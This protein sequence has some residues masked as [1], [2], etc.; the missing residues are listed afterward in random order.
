MCVIPCMG[1]CTCFIVFA[2]MAE[3]SGLT[4]GRGKRAR[5]LTS[6]VSVANPGKRRTKVRVTG[7]I[8]TQIITD[9]QDKVNSDAHATSPKG[10]PMLPLQTEQAASEE[11]FDFSEQVSVNLPSWWTKGSPRLLATDTPDHVESV[12]ATNFG[13]GVDLDRYLEPARSI[14]ERFSTIEREEYK[15]K[16]SSL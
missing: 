4:Q 9:A 10:P 11:N 2:V 13:A 3:E 6:K 15:K 1:K 12:V 8:A 5:K 16:D 14:F 7:T